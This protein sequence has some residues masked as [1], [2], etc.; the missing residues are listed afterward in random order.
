[1]HSLTLTGPNTVVCHR[2]KTVRLRA[3]DRRD[4]RQVAT[5]STGQVFSSEACVIVGEL[6]RNNGDWKLRA[7]GQGY[8]S[9]RAGMG[10]DYGVNITD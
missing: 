2:L 8:Q 7:V 5:F 4:G 10:R 9:G 1:M 6:Y 3:L